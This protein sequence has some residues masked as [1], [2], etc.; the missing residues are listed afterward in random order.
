[1]ATE[2]KRSLP[3]MR[4]HFLALIRRKG[5]SSANILARVSLRWGGSS[6]VWRTV[7]TIQPS[8]SLRVDQ[9]PSP[10]FIFLR[11]TAS[12]RMSS[13]TSGLARTESME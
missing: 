6:S 12:F 3:S 9:L 10:F 5:A 4:C 1:M 11:D 8:S 7:S 2:M 13:E